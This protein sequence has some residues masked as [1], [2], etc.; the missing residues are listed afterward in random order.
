MRLICFAFDFIFALVVDKRER[1]FSC[2]RL[3][4]LFFIGT[5]SERLWIME[6]LLI[7]KRNSQKY[8]YIYI[9]CIFW[10]HRLYI[11]KYYKNLFIKLLRC[12]N[13][14]HCYI[15]CKTFV[16]KFYNNCSSFIFYLGLYIVKKKKK[17]LLVKIWGF[18]PFGVLGQLHHLP[19][20]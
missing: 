20:G 4:F 2:E 18:L 16:L 7:E 6:L 5:V 10:C 19:L 11:K 1:V 14:I 9:Y 13:Y 17:N 12:I 3:L 8:I 15:N